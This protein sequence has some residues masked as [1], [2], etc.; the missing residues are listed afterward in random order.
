MIR[1]YLDEAPI[2]PN[3]PSWRCG[4]PKELEHV[5]RTLNRWW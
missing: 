5:W 2:L 1:Y 3:V 4:E